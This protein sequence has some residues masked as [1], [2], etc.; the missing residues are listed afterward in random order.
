MPLKHVIK[1]LYGIATGPSNFCGPLT[2]DLKS[3]E[4]RKIIPNFDPITC[5]FPEITKKDLSSD[6]KYLLEISQSVSSD[7]NIHSESVRSI[8]VPNK[9]K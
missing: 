8:M 9:K 5:E 6:Q 7:G 2:N 4:N 3:C 1:T